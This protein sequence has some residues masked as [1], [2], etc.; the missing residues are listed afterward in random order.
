MKRAKLILPQQRW[1]GLV[2][3]Y[4]ANSGTVGSDQL[5]AGS[6]NSDTNIKGILTKRPGGVLFGSLSNSPDDQYE[7]IFS[8]G[9]RHLLMM[10]GGT[11][12]YSTGDGLFTTAKAGYS[13]TGNMEFAAAQDR[14]YFG[15]AI[16]APQVYDR[17]AT[18]GG[19]GYAPGTIT[20]VAFAGLAG[21]TVTIGTTALVEGVNFTAATSNNAT[22]TSLA[23]AISGVSGFSASA[24]GAVITISCTGTAGA[25]RSTDVTN[26]TIA[27]LTGVRVKDMGPAAPTSALSAA[28]GAG[29]NVAAATYLY[30]V[31]FLY[32]DAQE[33]NGGTASATVSPGVPSQINLTAIPL[34]GYGV[35][36]RKIYRSSDAGGTYRLVATISNNTATT[37]TDNLASAGLLIPEDNNT[38]PTFGVILNHLS[39]FWAAKVAGDSSVLFFSAAELYDIFPGDFFLTC[40]SQDPIVGLIVYNDRV[41][42][43]N[44]NSFG[45]ILGTTADSFRYSQ[46]P[47]SIGCVDN[48]S[49]QVRTIRGVPTLI[50]LS[51][52]GVY[53]FNGST[54]EYLSDDIEDL[55]NVNIQQAAY[56]SGSQTDSA[57]AEF[58]SGTPTAGIVIGAGAVT[59]NNPKRTWQVAADW[60]GGSTLQRAVTKATSGQLADR[61]GTPQAKVFNALVDGSVVA[62]SMNNTATTL[63]LP[64]F[65]NNT[66]E[67]FNNTGDSFVEPPTVGVRPYAVAQK[68]TFARA[69]TLTNISLSFQTRLSSVRA[70]HMTVWTNVA[71]IPGTVVFSQDI[72]PSSGGGFVENNFNLSVSVALAA[73]TYWIGVD[74][75]HVPDDNSSFK[76]HSTS[77]TPAVGTNQTAV[78]GTNGFWY[79]PAYAAPTFFGTY[80]PYPALG[81]FSYTFVQTAVAT[82]GE[83]DSSILDLG[84][85]SNANAIDALVNAAASTL[86]AGQTATIYIDQSDVSDLSSGVTTVSTTI[87]GAASGITQTLAFS[88]TKRYW[89]IRWVLATADDRATP[90]VTN[91]SNT[92]EWG[93]NTTTVWISDTIDHSTDITALNSLIIT[94]IVQANTS[95]S[96]TIQ[97]SIL[98]SV[99]TDEGTFSVADGVQTISLASV[100]NPT[101]RYSRVK[102]TFTRSTAYTLTLAQVISA[103]L[104][105]TVVSTFI[106]EGID[107]GVNPPAGWDIFQADST[108]SV[109]FAMRSA[110]TLIG[111]AS[112]GWTSVTANVFPT[113]LSLRQFVQY[114][115]V[116]TA[117]ADAVPVVTSVTVNWF[118]SVTSSIRA[119]S[120]FFNKTYFLSVAEFGQT[121]NNVV[122][123][124][125][126]NG[127]W[128]RYDGVNASTL[129][130]FFQKPHYGDS[131]VARV[132][133]WLEGLT[134]LGTNITMDLRFKAFDFGDLTVRKL[135]RQVFVVIKNT[136]A[137][138]NAYYSVDNG[139]TFIALLDS[140]GNASW[141][142]GTDGTV[143]V[144]RLV[145]VWATNAPGKTIMVRLVNAD[146]K[147]AEVHE[148]HLDAFIRE[149]EI[150]YG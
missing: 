20:I 51:D 19:V 3:K 55:V 100:T 105:A 146:G 30:K 112:E 83:W 128:H 49:I 143:V 61:I 86:V 108:G 122:L 24:V 13:A 96:V 101:Q 92:F 72:F 52:K 12:K 34:G 99:F 11:L 64:T 138:F 40:N 103:T 115:L 59:Q 26:L 14:V 121:T 69:G 136:G 37:A 45:Q 113:G 147:E 67:S 15:N 81:A 145:P 97:K 38:P 114:R 9:S 66:G 89:R 74:S 137:T 79:V 94:A 1:A 68:V 141:T 135:L 25:I 85:Y 33:S 80:V 87:T 10:D 104:K 119:A 90:T 120:L 50:W 106:G 4:P 62:G 116:L 28:V 148:V 39:R 6:K 110:T 125:D 23:T 91:T 27:T 82:S 18:Y 63:A 65:G 93:W 117:T 48:R 46:V 111:L 5:T 32:Y 126:E 7:A 42:V 54:V 98:G 133:R 44:R 144:K 17:T 134:D 8:D 31:T 75:S 29:G 77:S 139:T 47:G 35:T 21:D 41:V 130:L 102:L 58:N 95:I 2:T 78:L 36:A 127:Q 150:L 131:N 57:D 43:F 132:V 71:G 70:W 123:A 22:A 53:G 88:A 109:T 76:F 140:A 16:G 118:T 124:Y 142:V 60:E 129:G 73:G 56:S 149:G 84:F 107:T